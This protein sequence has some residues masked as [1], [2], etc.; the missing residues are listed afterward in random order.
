MPYLW[1]DRAWQDYQYWASQDKKTCRR[2]NA[3]LKEISR[4]ARDGGRPL[5]K[6]ERLRYSSTGLC[7]VRIDRGQD[8]RWSDARRGTV[9]LTWRSR[10]PRRGRTG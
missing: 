10:S 7:S 6:A 1:D 4:A 3:L 5:G 8:G 9:G 2:I